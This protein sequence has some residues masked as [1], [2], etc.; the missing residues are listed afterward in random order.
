MSC[1]YSIN[2]EQRIG[3]VVRIVEIDETKVGK[4]RYKFRDWPVGVRKHRSGLSVF[5]SNYRDPKHTFIEPKE[6]RGASTPLTVAEG[7]MIYSDC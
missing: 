7:K 3:E 6:S 4:R 5:G 1:H 2:L